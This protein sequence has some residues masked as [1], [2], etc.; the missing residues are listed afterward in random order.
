VFDAS[1]PRAESAIGVIANAEEH[2]PRSRC[3]TGQPTEPVGDPA[4]SRTVVWCAKSVRY[5]KTILVGNGHTNTR[6]SSWE[7]IPAGA[8]TGSLIAPVW[9]STSRLGVDRDARFCR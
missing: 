9:A 7:M 1:A 6:D 2:L 8:Y 3:V 5:D 4:S